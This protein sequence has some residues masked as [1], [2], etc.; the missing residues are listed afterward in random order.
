M[1]ELRDDIDPEQVEKLAYRGWST[2]EIADFYECTYQTIRNRFS[3][4]LLKART[5]RKGDLRDAQWKSAVTNGNVT[6]Q[7]WLGKQEL[8]QSE[9]GMR[10]EDEEE[11]PFKE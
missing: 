7:I 10:N 6:M 8:D 2:K 4:I 9:Y 5:S 1:P 11:A 3:N